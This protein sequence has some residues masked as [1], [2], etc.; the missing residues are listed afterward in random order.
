MFLKLNRW[1]FGMECLI[2]RLLWV[3]HRLRGWLG[4]CT[5]ISCEES[6]DSIGQQCRVTPGQGNLR[7]SATENRPPLVGKGETVG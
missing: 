5:G 7:E 4:G 3:R 2:E 6:P 1:Q